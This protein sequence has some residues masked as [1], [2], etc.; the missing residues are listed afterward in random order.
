MGVVDSYI[1]ELQVHQVV[2]CRIALVAVD[3]VDVGLTY[4]KMPGSIHEL[5]T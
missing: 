4:L 1:E 5:Q 2:R 3:I